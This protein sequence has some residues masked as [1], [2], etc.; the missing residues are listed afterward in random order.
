MEG[1]SFKIRG[2][3]KLEIDDINAT[4][5]NSSVVFEN[6]DGTRYTCHFTPARYGGV[7]CIV[8]ES[9]LWRYHGDGDIKFLTGNNNEYTERA[10][11]QLFYVRGYDTL[12]AEWL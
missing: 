9:S 3:T 2:L 10:L 6:G 8:N 7:Y 5:V 11:L 4:W 12:W 1:D